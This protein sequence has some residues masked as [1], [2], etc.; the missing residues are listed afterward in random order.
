METDGGTI[1][2]DVS[3]IDPSASSVIADTHSSA[4]RGAAAR[5]REQDKHIRYDT[6]AIGAGLR[7]VPLV[8]ETYGLLGAEAVDFFRRMRELAV[9]R[10][11]SPALYTMYWGSYLSVAAQRAQAS[12]LNAASANMLL[13]QAERCGEQLPCADFAAAAAADDVVV[14]YN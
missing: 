8:M 14:A 3:F 9:R 2:A 11:T 4:V 12:L 1:V 6:E 13:A 10:G 7:F 5:K